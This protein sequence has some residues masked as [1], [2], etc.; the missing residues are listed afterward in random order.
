MASR[1]TLE[2]EAVKLGLASVS[3]YQNKKV[4]ES[5]I[6]RV[7]NGEDA[8]VVDN[9]LQ[10]E[11]DANLDGAGDGTDQP[12]NSGLDA[13]VIE[14]DSV[15]DDEIVDENDDD[16]ADDDEVVEDD[17]VTEDQPEAPKKARKTVKNRNNGHAV[18]FDETGRPLMRA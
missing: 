7:K 3:T 2:A 6:E 15:E 13:E 1:D 16:A 9:E 18:K 14:D 17:E 12:L 4:V 10:Q 8:A 11:V 5:A